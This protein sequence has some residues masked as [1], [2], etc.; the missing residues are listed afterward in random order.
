MLQY[1][2]CIV[3]S[4]AG[5][6]SDRG[7]GYCISGGKKQE[8]AQLTPNLLLGFRVVK[9]NLADYGDFIG[10]IRGYQI[11][12]AVSKILGFTGSPHGKGTENHNY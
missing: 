2:K 3:Y 10:A 5:P 4:L 7:T 8:W 12:N 9:N 6:I 1:G 11:A